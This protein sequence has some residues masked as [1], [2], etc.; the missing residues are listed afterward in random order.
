MSIMK[1]DGNGGTF[2]FGSVAATRIAQKRQHKQNHIGENDTGNH[3]FR[4]R[5]WHWEDAVR[6]LVRRAFRSRKTLRSVLFS[7][8]SVH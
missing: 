1:M 2:N 8:N 7:P 6:F 4:G 3:R 5:H